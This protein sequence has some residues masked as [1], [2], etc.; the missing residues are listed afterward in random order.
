MENID[1]QIIYGIYKQYREKV[2]DIINDKGYN[3]YANIGN[4]L[5]DAAWLQVES[6]VTDNVVMQIKKKLK[7][8]EY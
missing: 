5:W 4:K 6:N 7:H 3:I 2:N 8:E 1:K